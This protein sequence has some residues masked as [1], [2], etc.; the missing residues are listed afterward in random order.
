MT[1]KNSP[2]ALNPILTFNFRCKGEFREESV[3]FGITPVVAFSPGEYVMTE[4]DASLG[5]SRRQETKKRRK[6]ST[7]AS[8][9]LCSSN[10][11]TR[12]VAS[13][14]TT[15]KSPALAVEG[16]LEAGTAMDR[17]STKG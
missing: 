2:R 8:R 14:R 5:E 12:R 9:S 10:P 16:E 1:I 15:P 3:E 11:A 6:G 17:Y 7:A 13:H 4:K